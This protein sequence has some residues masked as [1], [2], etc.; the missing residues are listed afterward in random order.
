[1]LAG[2][3]VVASGTAEELEQSSLVREAFFGADPATH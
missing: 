2:G 1:V 3:K